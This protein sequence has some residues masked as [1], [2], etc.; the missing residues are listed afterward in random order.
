MMTGDS[1]NTVSPR[2]RVSKLE[3]IQVVRALAAN[4]VVADHALLT[5]RTPYP[6]LAWLMG[7]VGVWLF[8]VVSGLIMHH[9]TASE[10]RS[11]RAAGVFLMRRFI[12]IIPLYWLFTFLLIAQALFR[13]RAMQADWIVKSL[14]FIPYIDGE[15]QMHPIVQQGWTL[16][17]EM[18]FYLIFAFSLL[19]PR[20]TFVA[21]ALLSVMSLG[22]LVTLPMPLSAWTDPVI[23]LFGA[24]ILASV[25]H[26]HL[27]LPGWFAG[28]AL[29]L[30]CL[31]A[32]ALVITLSLAPTYPPSIGAHVLA[33]LA[34]TAIVLLAALARLRQSALTRL[35]ELLGNASY[36]TYLCHN[37]VINPVYKLV[38]GTT[39]DHLAVVIMVVAANIVG[40]VLYFMIETPLTRLL[41]RL[42]YARTL[43][44]SQVS[45]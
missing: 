15:G 19:L 37:I 34:C 45:A 21:L 43:S 20:R 24:G 22:S 39:G 6:Q 29:P 7:A 26:P 42:I 4:L 10:V 25:A 1:S 5:A 12:R 36:S 17:Y 23:L 14:L 32:I 11:V 41:R 2:P 16:D 27:T 18:M 31:A 30:G 9:T 3:G 33:W 28:L 38:S 13:D 8:F 44:K 40:I 35:I